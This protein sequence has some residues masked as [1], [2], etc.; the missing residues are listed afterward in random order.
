MTC[1]MEETQSDS[2]STWV[3]CCEL[4]EALQYVASLSNIWMDS[5]IEISFHKGFH[6]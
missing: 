1:L 5:S 4:H 3:L 2:K 6:G